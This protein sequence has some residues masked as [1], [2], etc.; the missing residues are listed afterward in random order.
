MGEFAVPVLAVPPAVVNEMPP[1]VAMVL[2]V[3]KNLPANISFDY[4]FLAFPEDAVFTVANRE[5]TATAVSGATLY[6]ST[7]QSPEGRWIVYLSGSGTL[8]YTLPAVPGA[9]DDLGTGDVATFDPIALSGGLT[10]EDLI[11]FNGDDLDR[12]NSL[13]LAF[14][15]HQL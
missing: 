15:H 5:M 7:I 14:T 10:F 9:M 13:S 8:T 12:I 3:D 11:T 6:R 1:D 4:G 2:Y